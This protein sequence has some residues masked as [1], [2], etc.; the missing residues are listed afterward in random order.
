MSGKT[1]LQN[2]L[3]H[4]KWEVYSLTDRLSLTHHIAVRCST[5]TN[6]VEVFTS[7]EPFGIMREPLLLRSY[8]CTEHP[9][10][11][12]NQTVTFN[13][14]ITNIFTKSFLSCA[15]NCNLNHSPEKVTKL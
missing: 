15:T 4:V 14:A 1:H 2:G 13:S 8:K 3:L 10:K 7:M 11:S 5:D 9:S 6:V 12:V